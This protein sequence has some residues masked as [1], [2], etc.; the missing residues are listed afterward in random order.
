MEFDGPLCGLH[1]EVGKHVA[2]IQRHCEIS[3]KPRLHTV[4]NT[5]RPLLHCTP[6]ILHRAAR[7]LYARRR[8]MW[9]MTSYNL[10]FF[11]PLPTTYFAIVFRGAALVTVIMKIP[12]VYW[13]AT[14]FQHILLSCLKL[15]ATRLVQIGAAC[16][17]KLQA[18]PPLKFP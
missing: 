17:H 2:Q 9:V 6:K 7:Y 12:Y 4:T 15:F 10:T 1:G 5:K 8:S 13:K 11:M 18:P 14:D 3:G 16:M